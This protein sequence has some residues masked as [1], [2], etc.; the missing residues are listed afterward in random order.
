MRGKKL[1]CIFLIMTIIVILTW[2]INNKE[3]KAGGSYSD[4]IEQPDLNT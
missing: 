2:S 1:I 4:G 3:V